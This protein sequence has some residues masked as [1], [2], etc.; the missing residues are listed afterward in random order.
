MRKIFATLKSVVAAALVVS[1]TL[2]VSC[3]YDDAAVKNDIK[4]LKGDL[5]KLTE[6]VNALE[7][8]DA[9][10]DL[11][12]GAAVITDVTV[13]ETTGDTVITLSNGETVTVLAKGLQYRV[14]EGVLEISADGQTWVAVTVAPEAVVKS[15]VDNE[16]GTVTITLANDE[17]FT[18]A[19]A[20]L[21]ECEAAR[22]QVYVIAG[23]TKAIRFTINDAVE[24][25]NIMNQPFGWSATVEEYVEVEADDDFGGGAMP[26]AV[27][28]KEYVLNIAGPSQALVDAGMAAKEGVVSV[29]FNTANGACKVLSVAVNL[30]EVTLNVDAAGNITITNTMAIEQTNRWDE[31]FTDFADFYIGVMPKALYDAHGVN[32]LDEDYL[33]WGDFESSRATHRSTGLGNVTDLMPYEEGVYEKEVIEL[34]VDQFGGAFDP[35]YNFEIGGEY[36]IFISHEGKMTQDGYEIP[37]LNNAIFATYKKTIVEAELV[38][39]SEK[40]NSA[41][42]HVSLAGYDNFLLGWITVA[43]IEEYMSYGTL[44]S[45]VEEILPQH[46]AAYGVMSAGAIIAGNY[47]DQDINL[48]DL[49][50]MSLMKWAPEL[51]PNTEYYFYV[52]PFNAQTEKDF[53]MHNFVAENL[54]ICG[55]F[56]TAALKAGSFDAG[57]EFELVMH[58]EKEIAVNVTFSE[59]VKVV[60][61]NWYDAEFKDPDAAVND[62]MANVYTDSVVFDEE[63]TSV[64]AEH[65][66]YYGLPNPVYLAIVALNADG[67]YVLVQ[68]EYTYVEPQLPQVE[69][70]SF[71]Y[72]GRHFDIDDDP[73]TSGGDHVYIAKAGDGTEFTIGLYYTYADENGVITSGEYAYCTNYFNAMYGAWNGFVIVSDTEYN[74][75]KLIVSD[76]QI[77]LKLKGIAEYVFNKNAAPVEPEQP[78]Q[79][80]EPEVVAFTSATV[81]PADDNLNYHYITFT[82]GTYN[83]IIK[84]CTR[85]TT[86]YVAGLYDQNG[87]FSNAD[88]L[89]IG[90]YSTDC[91]WNG[92]ECRPV[93][94]E[95]IDNGDGTATFNLVYNEYPSAV[96][97]KGTYTGVLEGLTLVEPEVEE[98][99]V[100]PEFVIPGEGGTY[101]MDYRYTTLV[102]GL[103][104]NN[105]VRVAQENGWTWDIKFNTGL[106]SIEAGDYTA[107]HYFSSETALEVDTYNGGFQNAPFNYIYPDEFDKVTTF[108]VQKE[109]DIYCITM[110]GSGGY[111]NDKGAYR[112]VY[113][114]KINN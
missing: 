91:T 114:G 89:Y 16:D 82:D 58:E 22:S 42:Y 111:G 92:A 49:K 109:G 74:D 20:E 106:A 38:E 26:L 8:N 25:I 71:E 36:V 63:T 55:T 95:V 3:S 62:I 15:V 54:K 19:K 11:L 43:Q 94:M 65:Y 104:A 77:V 51:S 113:I 96:Q 17:E 88:S 90:G 46:I 60:Y 56:E 87:S 47:L 1:M 98:E 59:D 28:G 40:W 80:A 102:D 48:A 68:K 101:A 79:P 31:T 9:I 21:I 45:T 93:T 85:G 52:Y 7:N 69:L 12:D 41:T 5:A 35:V 29:H 14:V 2:A 75:S 100:L 103:D 70:T 4:N 13:N 99:V 107:V 110:I 10:K 6:R 33:Q 67:E 34:T 37:T 73:E 86:E 105:A 30:A 83:A 18:V 84:L 23:T 53:Y 32:A 50:Q 27:G 39:G 44:G 112:L 66:E 57:A 64:S 78:E 24:D 61:Y 76:D 108:N 97:H 72:Q 81:A